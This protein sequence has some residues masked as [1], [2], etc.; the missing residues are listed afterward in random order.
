MNNWP[1]S[2]D[3]RAVYYSERLLNIA[4]PCSMHHCVHMETSTGWLCYT[5]AQAGKGVWFVGFYC[6]LHEFGGRWTS[7]LQPTITAVLQD[8][9]Q[10]GFDIE[11][12]V[13]RR[14]EQYRQ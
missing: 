14:D 9:A 2:H 11:G 8:A 1:P 7:E 4:Y 13:R 12:E 3:V 6:P 10:A 5:P